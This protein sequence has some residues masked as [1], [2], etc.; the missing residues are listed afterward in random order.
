MTDAAEVDALLA[1]AAKTRKP[2]RGQFPPLSFERS[3][4]ERQ[5]AFVGGQLKGEGE[6]R[7]AALCRS[8]FQ[9][10]VHR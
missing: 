9:T 6:R 8:P 1:A 4:D 3:Q 7:R 2:R 5:A 10:R